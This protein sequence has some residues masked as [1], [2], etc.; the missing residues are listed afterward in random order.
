MD[1]KIYITVDVVG[2]EFECK[3]C[4]VGQDSVLAQ[5][6]NVE[7]VISAFNIKKSS[8]VKNGCI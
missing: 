7:L 1:G 5:D 2:E 3:T 6:S 4:R 8:H